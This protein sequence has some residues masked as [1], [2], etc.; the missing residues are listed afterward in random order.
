M[1]VT[2]Y[3]RPAALL[4][5]FLPG[6][7]PFDQPLRKLAERASRH[8]GVLLL[9]R[10]RKPAEEFVAGTGR[11]SS[12]RIRTAP[13]DTPWVRDC[14]PLAVARRGGFDWVFPKVTL[15]PDR[16]FDAS[17]FAALTRRRVSTS[18]IFAAQGNVVAGPRGLVLSSRT[19]LL[20]NDAGPDFDFRP[21][22]RA[23]GI[24]RWLFFPT[25]ERELTGHADVYVRFLSPRLIAVAES[26]SDAGDRRIAGRIERAVRRELPGVATIRLP[27][28]S[29]DE[30][31]ASPVNWVQIGHRLFVPRYPLTTA[32]DVRTIGDRLG[33]AGY[34]VEFIPCDTLAQGGALHC[35]SASIYV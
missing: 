19:V 17:L 23:L 16:T 31:Y 20:E 4:V 12:F 11:P 30:A 5:P 26:R 18:P 13:F 28:R 3:R 10:E 33:R 6:Y 8:N 25:F 35:L 1:I 21:A 32:R 2:D 9:A 15:P 27:L 24:R 22:K 7:E 29:E 14:A 34:E